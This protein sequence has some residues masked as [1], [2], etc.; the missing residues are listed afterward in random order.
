MRTH[1]DQVLET[2]KVLRPKAS[3][4]SLVR[5]GGESD[6]AYL[7]PDDLEGITACFSPGV[8]NSKSFEDELAIRYGIPSHLCDF[9]SDSSSMT[10]P[11]I[12]GMQTFEKKWLDIH[13]DPDSISLSEWVQRWN[14][15][16]SEDLLLQMDIEGAEY[17][18]LLA[19]PPAILERFRILVVE[20]HGVQAAANP[21]D[22]ERQLGPLLRKIG[23]S[24]VCVHARANNCCGE[25][26][27]GPGWP[28][29]PSVM[30]VTFLR[31]DRMVRNAG[32]PFHKPLLPHPLDISRN[33]DSSAPL[34]LNQ[35]WYDGELDARSHL[36]IITD[37][38][39]YLERAL[40]NEIKLA[41]QLRRV[42]QVFHSS[43]IPSADPESDT[44]LDTGDIASG[45]AFSL[46]SA[47]SGED[48]IGTVTC[49]EPYFFH[50][51]FGL[52]EA[53]TID[54]EGQ[55]VVCGLRLTNRSDMASERA[56]H[57]MYCL[58]LQSEPDYVRVGVIPATA[59][60]LTC[61]GAIRLSVRES[62]ARFVTIF[63]PVHTAIHL[64]DLRV[65]A[66]RQ[67]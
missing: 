22:F 42:L 62:P 2:L 63:S 53:I 55:F 50:T 51:D 46:T 10:T 41:D 29:L 45:C 23:Q 67:D 25:I 44:S 34:F 39:E 35:Y 66:T 18:N 65:Y 49:R 64:S 47:Y 56:S 38:R 36:K 8:N 27:L 3:P 52:M 48:L 28:N 61:G 1:V 24:F 12:D 20:F 14:P 5:V 43:D 17:R 9:T 13:G 32:H 58:H 4:V 30:E 31:N 37:Q 6:G 54:L 57:L 16:P 11:L 60:F 15:N 59:E 33:V 7:L 19:T 21:M 40:K 26:R